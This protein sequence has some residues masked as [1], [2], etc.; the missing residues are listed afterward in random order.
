MKINYIT[1]AR[2]PTEKAHGWQ[3]AKMCEA[4]AELGHEVE[5]VIPD[6]R[7]TITQT[8]QEFY[9]LKFNFKI[10]RLPVFDALAITWLPRLLAFILTE[11]S[12]LRAVRRWTKAQPR[13]KAL[14][15]TRDQFL[16]HVLTRADW[17]RAF[18]V[19]DI[20]PRFFWL[21]KRLARTLDFIVTTN[22]WKKREIEKRWG[23]RRAKIISLPNAIDLAPYRGLPDKT[24]SKKSLGWDA[25]KKYVLYTGHLYA[26]K[27]VYVLAEASKFLPAEAHI[28]MV[29]GTPEDHTRLQTYLKERA[30]DKVT[31]VPHVAHEKLMLYMAAA[32]CFVLPNSA[33]YWHSLY[34]T[35]PIKL[36]EYLAARRPLVASDLPS[37]RE[38]VNETEVI[39]VAPDDPRALAHGINQALQ[40]EPDK[41]EAGWTRVSRQ[42]WRSRAEKIVQAV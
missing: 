41:V 2:F 30:L 8:A 3:I 18:E 25:T 42:T 19:H 17:T 39:Y 38:L 7:N 33:K 11:F 1:E 20:T 9:K 14:A 40:G 12:F 37:I 24:E 5:L 10:T 15:F 6:R 34:T 36:W 13:G 23:K 21:H 27:G 26:W 22:E 28:V 32:E 31:L 35:S 29:G 16:A 4:F